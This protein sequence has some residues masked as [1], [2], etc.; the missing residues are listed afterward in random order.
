MLKLRKNIIWKKLHNK[1][2]LLNFKKS[3]INNKKIATKVHFGNF[4]L[5]AST[6]GFL[7]FK[8]IGSARRGISRITGRNNKLWIRIYPDFSLTKKNK[9]S[10][11]GKGVGT[12][13]LWVYFV[14]KGTILFELNKMSIK[15]VYLAFNSANQKLPFKCTIVKRLNKF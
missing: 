14:K 4:G 2:H 1:T 13:Y 12:T 15:K 8:Q 7:T 3:K 5:K 9:N 11:M 10:R 6:S